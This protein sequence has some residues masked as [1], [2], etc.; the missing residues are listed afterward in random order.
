[1]KSF[2]LL[3]CCL[4]IVGLTLLNAVDAATFIEF[5]NFTVT[6]ESSAPE[7]GGGWTYALTESGNSL[8]SKSTVYAE[9]ISIHD[10]FYK[11]SPSYNTEH[12]GF[13]N[14]GFL[15]ITDS[16]VMSG[17]ALEYVITGGRNI[18]TCPDPSTDCDDNGLP[19]KNKQTYLD[20]IDNSQEPVEGGL[21]VGNPYMY[22]TNNSLTTSPVHFEASQGTNRLSFYIWMPSGLNIGAGGYRVAPYR[23]LSIGPYSDVPL[24]DVFPDDTSG[25]RIGGHFYN[26]IGIN[27]GGWI[28]VQ[29]DGHPQH[30]NGFSNKTYY[31][32][33]SKS[34]R[35]IGASYFT[36]MYRF[37]ITTGAYNGLETP[38]FSVYL[39]K[40]EFIEDTE[41]QNN[42]T[43]NTLGILYKA[44]SKT[45]EIAFKDKYKDNAYSWATY[46][47]RYSFSPITNANW[48]SATPAHIIEN[49]GFTMYESTLGKIDKNTPYYQSVW[50]P[51]KLTTTDTAILTVGTTV[52]F[53]VKDIGN[54]DSNGD[55]TQ[56]P[57]TSVSGYE[58]Y[59]GRD[60][61]GYPET[62]DW[63]GDSAVLTLIRRTDFVISES[64]LSAPPNLKID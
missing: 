17:N 13:E 27:G 55:P 16:K 5:D 62:F 43:I 28:H 63:A 61:I 34:F 45:F 14:Y 29:I 8:W 57:N 59:G 52:Y 20:Y 18:T 2:Y 37:Y 19:L 53:A 10:L 22:F 30:N 42:E 11:Y 58:G 35:D 40:V 4:L 50:A 26:D 44:D 41:P 23:T 32:F 7:S 6:E 15:Q 31:P 49:S 60:Y 33:P 21:V 1:M 46:E 54:I 51:F 3:S 48:S 56:T 36:N 47:L 39:D 9:D 12:M 25:D 24:V 64:H 38:K